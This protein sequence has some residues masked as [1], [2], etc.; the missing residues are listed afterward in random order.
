[1][2]F[3]RAWGSP[4]GRARWRPGAAGVWR[5]GDHADVPGQLDA[6]AHLALSDSSAA[7]RGARHAA[8]L[9]RPAA[10]GASSWA[11]AA[12]CAGNRDAAVPA[13]W[14]ICAKYYAVVVEAGI[15]RRSA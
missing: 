8:W 6:G 3:Y 10:P 12:G 5:A 7:R 11:G 13:L 9:G 14:H 4:I 2:G 1:M 15:G